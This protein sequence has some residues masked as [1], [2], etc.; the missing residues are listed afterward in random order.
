MENEIL[1]ETE[2]DL[3]ETEEIQQTDVPIDENNT[4]SDVGTS[5]TSGIE[6]ESVLE[7]KLELIFF[8]MLIDEE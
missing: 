2:T 7:G 1:Q 5:E 3:L 4:V 8:Y 6:D